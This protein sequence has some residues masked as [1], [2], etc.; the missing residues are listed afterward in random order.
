L[1]QFERRADAAAM[2]ISS[3][4]PG[5]GPVAENAN[6]SFGQ[7]KPSSELSGRNVRMV[8]PRSSAN[9]DRRGNPVTSKEAALDPRLFRRYF[10]PIDSWE[11][12][13]VIFDA[14]DGVK[15]E[16]PQLEVYRQLTGAAEQGVEKVRE[17]WIKAGRR[18]GKSRVVAFQGIYRAIFLDPKANF[19]PGERPYTFIIC[20]DR[21][22]GQIIM[23][24]MRELL[25]LSPMMENLVARQ[26]KES[27]ELKN[28]RVVAIKTASWRTSRGYSGDTG[29]SDETNFLRYEVDSVTRDK[30][31]YRA[32]IPMLS[33]SPDSLFFACS[34]P[35]PEQG[36]MAEKFAKHWGKPGRVLC[37]SAPTLFL[38]PTFDKAEV[39]QAYIDDPEAARSEYGAEW[40]SGTLSLIDPERLKTVINSGVVELSPRA[41]VQYWGF[42][43]SSAGKSDS[44]SCGISSRGD[45]GDI[46]LDVCREWVPPFRPMDVC[47]G[48]AEL[49]K[50][51]H[52]SS[53]LA[54]AFSGEWL[55]QGMADFG[56]QVEKAPMTKSGYYLGL[57]PIINNGTCRI[58]D[59]GKLINQ[60]L[61]LERRVRSGALDHVDV[62]A[63]H[64]DL[65]NVCAGAL[66]EAR[67][68]HY[69]VDIW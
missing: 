8:W 18:S 50:T 34:S 24:Y 58:L 62:F 67:K 43:D 23:G 54:D 57:L 59:Q 10:E 6:L 39:D 40:R 36:L 44:F 20:P 45:N 60:L 17:L 11:N 16:G 35:G 38:N 47:R 42:L 29:I 15:L 1:F 61:N 26:F 51:Y 2:N 5:S 37:I 30:E 52:I 12:W 66:V 28:G 21:Q 13:F 63:G 31:I 7:Q 27:I 56:I 3:V 53:V 69:I 41:G 19:R 14:I 9:S 55:R 49:L 48:V 46:I 33:T 65:A 68:D 25:S 32:V 4:V 22:Q 64:D